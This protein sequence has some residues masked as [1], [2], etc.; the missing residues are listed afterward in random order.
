MLAGRVIDSATIAPLHAADVFFVDTAGKPVYQM[1]TDSTGD[2]DARLPT[3]RYRMHVEKPGYTEFT[4]RWFD[5]STDLPIHVI[6]L[7]RSGLEPTMRDAGA[8]D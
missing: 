2:F 1:T 6:A 3:G 7:A 5:I 4:S 8:H